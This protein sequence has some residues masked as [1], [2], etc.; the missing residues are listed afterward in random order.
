MQGRWVKDCFSLSCA[1]VFCWWE[2][3]AHCFIARWGPEGVRRPE[4]S[5]FVYT[6]AVEDGKE[7]R[8]TRREWRC[9]RAGEGWEG[10]DA[11][12]YGYDTVV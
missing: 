10:R 12:G 1:C 6:R 4:D 3:I 9:G 7:Q 2:C 11:M 8:K 5:W